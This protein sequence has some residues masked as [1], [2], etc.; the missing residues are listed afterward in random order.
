M[1]PRP[2]RVFLC[3]ALGLLASASHLPAAELRTELR[4]PIAIVPAEDGRLVVANRESGSLSLVDLASQRVVAEQ[5]IGQR[6]SDL[7]SLGESQFLATDEEAHELLLVEVVGETVTVRERLP[8]SP[9]PVSICLADENK[10]AVIASLW[11][12]RLTFVSIG[13]A[14]AEKSLA[15]AGTVD[16]PFAP[17]CQHLLTGRDRLIVADAFGGRLGIVDPK[18]RELVE[19]RQFPGHNVRGVRTR[20]DGK[21]LVVAHQ[22]LNDLAHSIQNDIHWG[23]LMSNDLRWLEVD[24]VLAGGEKLYYGAHI[25]PLGDPGKGGG[26][27]GG[28]AMAADGTVCVSLSGVNL[29]ALGKENDFSMQ[30]I[31]VGRR[32]TAVAFSPDSGRL[33]VANTHD[34]SISVVDVAALEVSATISLGPQPTLSEAQQGELLFYDASLSHDGWMSCHSCHTDGHANGEMNDN[35]SDRSFGAPKRVLSLL[36]VGETAPYAWTGEV[37]TLARQIE[38]SI[39]KT[40][41]RGDQLP[42]EQVQAIAAYMRTLEIPPPVDVLRGTVDAAAVARGKEVFVRRNCAECHA[43]E[44]F[45]SPAAYDVGLVD[46]VGNRA[47]NPPSLRGLSHRGPY[48]HDSSAGSLAEVLTKQGHPGGAEYPAEEVNDLVAY[49]RSL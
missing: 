8:I 2:G 22:M 33:F 42:R 49:L 5:V 46:K 11:S 38:N 45:T 3:L 4:R 10:Q 13:P 23:L 41:Q 37:R 21:M 16:L 40:M 32:P 30:R 47:F 31:R 48:F 34:D 15:I 24:S 27:P 25:H 44:T 7:V 17:R 1:K 20:P 29:I 26:D 28:L 6:L 9:F 36:G 14:A 43:G 35:L 12:R 18:R 19:T 39:E